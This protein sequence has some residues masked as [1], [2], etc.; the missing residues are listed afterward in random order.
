MPRY[1]VW[2]GSHR[3]EI[4]TAEELSFDTLPLTVRTTS[5]MEIDGASIIALQLLPDRKPTRPAK[6]R[7]LNPGLG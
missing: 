4:E 3:H 2:F 1:T 7:V 6:R 5:G